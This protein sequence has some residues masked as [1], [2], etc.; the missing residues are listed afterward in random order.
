MIL[1]SVKLK[2]DTN[3]HNSIFCRFVS[4]PLGSWELNSCPLQKQEVQLTDEPSLSSLIF[5]YFN[6]YF[7]HI[8]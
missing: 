5:Q 8:L 7:K 1:D 4:H 2:V 3:H 6:K